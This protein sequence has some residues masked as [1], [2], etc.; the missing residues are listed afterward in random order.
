MRRNSYALAIDTSNVEN[1][2]LFL[3]SPFEFLFSMDEK[4]IE[5]RENSNRKSSTRIC[6]IFLGIALIGN[7]WTL[8]FFSPSIFTSEDCFSRSFSFDFCCLIT[9]IFVSV[10]LRHFLKIRR[11]FPNFHRCSK[12]IFVLLS[13]LTFSWPIGELYSDSNFLQSIAVGSAGF[14]SIVL[15]VEIFRHDDRS[16]IFDFLF[17]F[18]LTI[19]AAS[20]L[21]IVFL[22]ENFFTE[23]SCRT[24]NFFSLRFE[25]SQKEEK[26]KKNFRDVDRRIFFVFIAFAVVVFILQ[27][28]NELFSGDEQIDFRTNSVSPIAG[29]R[30][31][32]ISTFLGFQ[33]FFL[34]AVLIKVSSQRTFLS[35]LIGRK[36]ETTRTD[37]I[38]TNF[39]PNRLWII[40]QQF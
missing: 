29:F 14:S 5:P 3:N 30:S 28:R 1:A 7:V 36:I 17:S 18:G 34:Y 39:K 23:I 13:I 19:G 38:F 20:I 12:L 22:R 2:I 24:S 9:S 21:P 6:E 40:V 31:S 27:I 37:F 32:S 26:F 16:S 25:N 15:L 4:R 33:E 35:L 10:H 8:E 11:F